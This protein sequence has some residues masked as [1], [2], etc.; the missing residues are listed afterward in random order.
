MR[1]KPLE[2]VEHCRV[3]GGRIPSNPE[4]GNNGVFR[5]HYQ[6]KT[7]KATLI[8]L[9]SDGGGWDHISVEWHNHHQVPT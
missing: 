3:R 4:D 5:I 1:A 9:V 2:L 7:I 6:S 8:C